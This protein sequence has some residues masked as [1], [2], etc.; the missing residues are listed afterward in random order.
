MVVSVATELSAKNCIMLS[1]SGAGPHV[2][3][4]KVLGRGCRVWGL[5]FTLNPTLN[6]R[7][8]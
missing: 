7:R 3:G 8:S 6:P 5:G 1:A 4:F 2:F